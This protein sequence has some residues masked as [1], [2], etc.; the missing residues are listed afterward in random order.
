MDE[1]ESRTI[2]YI[3]KSGTKYH[4]EHCKL[5]NQN[6]YA[7]DLLSAQRHGY[8]P[9]AKCHPP[10]YFR[11]DDDWKKE[12]AMMREKEKIIE[13]KVLPIIITLIFIEFIIILLTSEYIG[14]FEF[15]YL[16]NGNTH[17]KLSLFGSLFGYIAFFSVLTLTP[18]AA[19]ALIAMLLEM[20]VFK[21]YSY[22]T[23]IGITVPFGLSYSL[24]FIL[25]LLVIFNII[26]LQFV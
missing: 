7:I 6:K 14:G 5:L 20:F 21:D 16:T 24:G 1:S 12:Y 2:V 8:T 3:T 9:C 17:E 23:K 18:A 15:Q 11:A 4:S 22:N 10:R 13:K 25:L 26:D 19:N